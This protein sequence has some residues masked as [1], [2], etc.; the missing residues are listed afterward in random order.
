MWAA[1]VTVFGGVL[2]YQSGSLLMFAFA[3]TNA[4]DGAGSLVLTLHFSAELR[5]DHTPRSE[6][7]AL[8]VIL[9]GIATV[10]TVTLGESVHRLVTGQE[11]NE[12]PYGIGLALCS[13]VVLSLLSRR[14]RKLAMRLFSKPLRADA[15][16]SSLGATLAG[17]TV[18]GTAATATLDWWWLDSVGA[19]TVSILAGMIAIAIARDE[20]S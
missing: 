10:V 18:A 5:N 1:I 16:L 2:A 12:S 17:I 20:R 11:V 7:I 14:K 8:M 15:H 13:V 3:A 19:A 4:L 6:R 9:G